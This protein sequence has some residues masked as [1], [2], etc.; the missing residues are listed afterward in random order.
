MFCQ[1]DIIFQPVHEERAEA[2]MRTLAQD[3]VRGIDNHLLH[4]PAACIFIGECG[5][6]LNA[7]K[8]KLLHPGILARPTMLTLLRV[9]RAHHGNAIIGLRVLRLMQSFN[10]VLYDI[11]DTVLL[12]DPADMVVLPPSE[13]ASACT[14]IDAYFATLPPFHT[15]TQDVRICCRNVKAWIVSGTPLNYGLAPE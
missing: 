10:H 7:L 8:M 2:M 3:L 4:C 11:R 6:L 1:R 13:R 9:L 15:I 5:L 12:S 14:V